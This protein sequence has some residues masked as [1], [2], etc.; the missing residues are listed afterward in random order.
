MALSVPLRGR[1]VLF[2]CGSALFVRHKKRICMS[3]YR[4]AFFVAVFVCFVWGLVCALFSESQLLHRVIPSEELRILLAVFVPVLATFAI[5]YRSALLRGIRPV[6]RVFALFGV[7][8]VI[9]AVTAG[10]WMLVGI[11]L[12][13]AI[14]GAP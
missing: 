11:L 8:S 10:L 4:P 14:G 3:A 12:F 5:L 2:G 7:G 6:P 9:L 13:L 1:R